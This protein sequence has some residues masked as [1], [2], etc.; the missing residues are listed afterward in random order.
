MVLV[1]VAGVFLG[2]HAFGQNRGT[3]A[4]FEVASVKAAQLSPAGSPAGVMIDEMRETVQPLGFIGVRGRLVHMESTSLLNLVAVA[5]RVAK[6]QVAGP[7][8][9]SERM[10]DVDAKLP[11]GAATGEVNSMLQTLLG[12][13]FG[14]Q[15]HVEGRVQ[16]GYELRLNNNALQLKIA[17]QQ[18]ENTDLDGEREQAKQALRRMLSAPSP[19][20]RGGTL[21]IERTNITA[22]ELAKLLARI[23]RIPIVDR[24]GLQGRYDVELEYSPEG[25]DQ[26]L[27]GTTIFQAVEKLGLRLTPANV[28]GDIVVV[29]KLNKTP[30]PN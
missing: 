6:S 29:D 11:E 21:R 14:L 24:T 5:Y 9:M 28:T 15:A 12:D 25:P 17:A 19:Q 7:A 4:T 2:L 13:R 26:E 10:F 8:W 27:K 3:S 22:G 1:C 18:A 23:V 20:M 16:K 30:T